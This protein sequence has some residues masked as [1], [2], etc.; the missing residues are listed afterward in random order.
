M[1]SSRPYSGETG[2]PL[3]SVNYSAEDMAKFQETF[4]PTAERYHRHR[5]IAWV[6]FGAGSCLL[7]GSLLSNGISKLVFDRALFAKDLPWY[8]TAVV[9]VCFAIFG[10][11]MISCPHLRCPGCQGFLTKGIGRFCPE[12]GSNGLETDLLGRPC[13]RNC[14]KTMKHGRNGMRFYRVRA[15]TSCGLMLDNRGL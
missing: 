10:V 15:C 14:G 8:V 1:L 5:R 6:A 2:R 7:I 3:N 9:F 12:C 11:A 4:G 13:C